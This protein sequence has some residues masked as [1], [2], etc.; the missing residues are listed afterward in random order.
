MKMR[1]KMKLDPSRDASSQK[2]MTL[3]Y[4]YL[5]G[6]SLGDEMQE[7]KDRWNRFVATSAQCVLIAYDLETT[8]KL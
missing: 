6:K 7:R 4:E 5:T 8:S 1:E 2:L 3:E